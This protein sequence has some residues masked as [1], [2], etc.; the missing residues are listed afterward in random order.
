[1]TALGMMPME[2]IIAATSSA[3]RLLGLD[4]EVGSIQ[5]GNTADLLFVEGNPLR[6]IALLTKKERLVAVMR[7][8]RFVM[9]GL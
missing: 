3:A 9:G 2:A 8:G 5:S 4:R 1:M 6:R 7:G